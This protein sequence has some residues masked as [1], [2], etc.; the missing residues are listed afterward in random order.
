MRYSQTIDNAQENLTYIANSLI[1]DGGIGERICMDYGNLYYPE[2]ITRNG[3]KKQK[4]LSKFITENN[5]Y[6]RAMSLGTSPR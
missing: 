4:T 2:N 1:N 6:V 5:V 3:L